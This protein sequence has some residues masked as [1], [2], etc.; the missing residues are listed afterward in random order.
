MWEEFKRVD[1]MDQWPA[2]VFSHSAP[3]FHD[4]PDLMAFLGSGFEQP[5]NV[6]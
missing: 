3:W 1:V 4:Q 6:L 2:A 5:G